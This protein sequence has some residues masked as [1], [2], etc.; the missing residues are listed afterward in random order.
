MLILGEGLNF[1]DYYGVNW[2][3]FD[4]CLNDLEWLTEKNILIRHKDLP[5]ENN[6][7]NAQIYLSILEDA[8]RK[9]RK[10]TV[11][12]LAVVFPLSVK[13]T[14]ESKVLIYGISHH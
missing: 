14:V 13:S 7:R 5:L 9:W 10:N 1:P 12:N 4:E 6:S 2:D 8:S 11:H 3:A